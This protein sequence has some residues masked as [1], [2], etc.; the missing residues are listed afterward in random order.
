VLDNFAKTRQIWKL[1]R[2]VPALMQW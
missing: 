2:H 1:D